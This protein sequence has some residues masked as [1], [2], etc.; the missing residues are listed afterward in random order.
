MVAIIFIPN[1]FYVYKYN[2]LRPKQAEIFS[3]NP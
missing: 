3:K 1:S 2:S